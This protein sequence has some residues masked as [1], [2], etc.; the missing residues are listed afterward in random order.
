MLLY[1]YIKIKIKVLS[2]KKK[3]LD[4][5]NSFYGDHRGVKDSPF[6]G[7]LYDRRGS[8]KNSVS[9]DGRAGEEG[10]AISPLLLTIKP[11]DCIMFSWKQEQ[12]S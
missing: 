4:M 2:P 7:E 1:L 11:T 9:F 5:I 10:I 12:Q 3:S 6:V 8:G